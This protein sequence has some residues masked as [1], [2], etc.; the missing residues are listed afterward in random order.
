MCIQVEMAER[1]AQVRPVKA[2]TVLQNQRETQ[3]ARNEDADLHSID[4]TLSRLE[5]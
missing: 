4:D 3:N 1:A 5:S 2:N